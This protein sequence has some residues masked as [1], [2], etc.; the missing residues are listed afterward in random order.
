M[1]TVEAAFLCPLLQDTDEYG[2]LSFRGAVGLGKKGVG[3]EMEN[4]LEA[5]ED[6]LEYD[7]DGNVKPSDLDPELDSQRSERK[8]KSPDNQR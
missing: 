2:L 8:K 6:E 7:D 5:E 4:E 3:L 1:L